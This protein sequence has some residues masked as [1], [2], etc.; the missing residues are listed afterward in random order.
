MSRRRRPVISKS[1]HLFDRRTSPCVVAIFVVQA[2]RLDRQLA[3]SLADLL[4]AVPGTPWTPAGGYRGRLVR[5]VNVEMIGWQQR[6]TAQAARDL[7]AIFPDI[8]ELSPATRLRFL[9][10]LAAIVDDEYGGAV[11]DPRLT[12]V[13]TALRTAKRSA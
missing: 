7:W 3:D 1:G 10:R 11:D 4:P 9:T 8:S 6:L 13:Y 12:V 2:R 5:D